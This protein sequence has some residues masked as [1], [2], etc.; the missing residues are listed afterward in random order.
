MRRYYLTLREQAKPLEAVTPA[1][2]PGRF[3]PP[4]PLRREPL[5]EV[6]AMVDAMNRPAW[7]LV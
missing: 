4:R 2:V 7:V 6:F 1:S 3:I 5:D